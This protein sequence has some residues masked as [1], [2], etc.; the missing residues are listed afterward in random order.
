M[1]EAFASNSTSSYYHFVL[2]AS[3]SGH[4]FIDL[5]NFTYLINGGQLTSHI[6]TT[7]THHL[8]FISIL[9]VAKNFSF[10]FKSIGRANFIQV[11]LEVSIYVLQH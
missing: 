11:G 8:F 6:A 9:L 1:L 4:I 2:P 10:T 3:G 5:R 7:F